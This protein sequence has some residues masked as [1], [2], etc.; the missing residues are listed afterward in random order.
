MATTSRKENVTAVELDKAIREVMPSNVTQ[1]QTDSPSSQSSSSNHLSQILQ[2]IEIE[3]ENLE[4]KQ[5]ELEDGQLREDEPSMSSN[6]PSR[7][8]TLNL[9]LP[10]VDGGKE[11]WIFVA[12]A[13][14]IELCTWGFVSDFSSHRTHP[15]LPEQSPPGS[16][17]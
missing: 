9:S 16:P 15:L 5:Q 7:T 12:A 14:W 8:S 1:T 10:P 13:F 4:P 2:G 6:L 11:A 17:V 3:M